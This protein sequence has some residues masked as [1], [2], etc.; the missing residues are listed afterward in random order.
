MSIRVATDIGGTFTDL[1]YLDEETGVLDLAKAPSTPGRLE[2]GILDSIDK[3]GFDPRSVAQFVHG[4][5][6]VIN[7]ITERKGVKVGLLT[8]WGMRDV[9]EIARG[10]RPDL[11]NLRYKKPEPFVPRHLRLEVDERLDP[12]GEVVVPLDEEDVT[13][14]ARQL[15]AE[16]VDAV[17]ICFLH[18]YANPAHEQRAGAIVRD[19]IPGVFLSLSHEITRE[20]REY[21]RTNTAVMNSYVGPIA[22][23]YL[24]SLTQTLGEIGV[25]GNL[26]I[27]QSNGG[28][29]T[30]SSARQTPINLVESGPVGGVIGAAE[31][32]RVIGFPNLITLDIGGTTAKT[33]LVQDNELKV[34]T[35]YKL[36]W[37][38][39]WAGYPVKVP[40]VDIVEIGAGGGSIAWVDANGALHVGPESAGA[41][42][43][44][45]SYG[46]GG[47]DPTVTDANLIAGRLDPDYFLGGEMPL[48]MDKARASF[49]PLAEHF[50]ISVEEAALGVIRVANAN[51]M[52]ALKIISVQRGHDP[53]DF[54]LVA[55]GGGGPV[56]TAWLARELQI[57]NV[58]VPV[59][60]AHFSALGM[61][62]TDLRRD[63]I[64]T[65]V[66]RTDQLDLDDLT[67]RYE[68]LEAQ[69]T[70]SYTDE[71][72]D[73]SD[74]WFVRMADMRY[75]GQEHTVR[76]P[77]PGGELAAEDLAEIERRFHD[78]HEQRYTFRLES[79]IEIVNVHLTAYGRVQKP[80]LARVE[81]PPGEEAAAKG[82]RMVDFD[83]HGRQET[84]VY[85]RTRLG[86]GASIEGPAVIEEA[87]SNTIVY[88]G[89]SVATDEYGNLI[90][91]TGVS[92]PGGQ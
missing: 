27:M 78:L 31:M 56:H 38:P 60:P 73:P 17:A 54:A 62:M 5:T 26:H 29:A 16:G 25:R 34:T 9:L 58:I 2:Q 80:E 76:V 37:T 87:A 47:T 77:V 19:V 85:D 32:G 22:A 36:E 8:T 67:Q 66:V 75:E 24:D 70:T 41:D 12:S 30:M 15:R 83:E 50:G 10:N 44:P 20:W 42:P 69:A 21:E 45:A 71:G 90:I 40:V 33:A 92:A 64:Q 81:G 91:D 18:S 57:E 7:T 52:N 46:Q 55:I 65:R 53:R 61:L 4:T 59:A 72:L 51:M 48:D 28:T 23:A 14:A 84:R 86:P 3:A 89:M 63:Y 88:P 43:G 13:R 82:T 79:L 49:E 35:E 1:V 11:Y 39:W 6:V 74:V 68:A